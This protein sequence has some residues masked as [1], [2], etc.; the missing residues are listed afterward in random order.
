MEITETALF[1][2]ETSSDNVIEELSALGFAIVLDDFGTGYSSLSHVK[3]FPVAGIKID[4]SFIAD[5]PTSRDSVPIVEALIV[6]ARALRI[7][8][9]AEGIETNGQADLLAE[10][11]CPAGQGWLYSSAVPV[12]D[13]P[14]LLGNDHHLSP[15]T[16]PMTQNQVR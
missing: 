2:A 8:V 13:L 14:A 9:V 15:M 6:M 5:I 12:D 1:E 4:R 7:H 3:R 16:H 11:G 10:L